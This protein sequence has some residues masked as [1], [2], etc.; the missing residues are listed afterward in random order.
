[1][2]GKSRL[3]RPQA[4]SPNWEDQSFGV[5]GYSEGEMAR[6]QALCIFIVRSVAEKHGGTIEIDL[7]TDTMKINVPDG[8]QMACAKEIEEQVLGTRV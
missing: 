3:S 2:K 8:E 6:L 1:M 5:N 7:A 4:R